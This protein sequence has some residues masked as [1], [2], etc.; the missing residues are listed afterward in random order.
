VTRPVEETLH[1]Y[2]EVA[3]RIFERIEAEQGQK[4]Q[5]IQDQPEFKSPQESALF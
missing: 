1:G 5:E 2:L 3:W 4:A